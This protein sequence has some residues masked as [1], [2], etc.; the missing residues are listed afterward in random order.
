MIHLTEEMILAV[1]DREP[2]ADEVLAH[3]DECGACARALEDARSRA[4]AVEQALAALTVPLGKE[5]GA[6]AA[7][8]AAQGGVAEVA[9]G[10]EV[11]RGLQDTDAGR[12]VAE[13]AAGRGRLDGAAGPGAQVVPIGRGRRDAGRGTRLRGSVWSVRWLGRAAVLV[14]IG[15]GALSALPGPFNG[16]IPRVFSGGSPLATPISPAPEP[17]P[18]GQVGG[19]MEVVDGP[20]LVRLENVVP[21]T[22]I[23]VR[24]VAGRAVGVLAA[25]GSEF[26]YG[27]GEVRAAVVAG[28]VTV[29]L[30]DGV[31]PA[32]LIVNGATYLVVDATG[33]DVPGPAT[34]A[35]G[36]SLVTFQVPN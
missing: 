23:D 19:R 4:E 22:V 26:S 6:Q 8:G 5:T 29:E 21:G 14:L 2:V 25:T 13:V 17:G 24:R 30:P 35:V 1:R 10:P 33:I 34:A 15:A 9:A 16:W 28:P 36:E 32:T 18:P 3:L 11:G 27:S 31:V 20:V 7:S 12:L